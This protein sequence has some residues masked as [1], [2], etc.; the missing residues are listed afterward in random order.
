MVFNLIVLG[1]G[2]LIPLVV[3]MKSSE[4][5]TVRNC[6]YLCF[7]V[8]IYSCVYEVISCRAEGLTKYFSSF[9][10]GIDVFTIILYF[11]YFSY[12]IN[13]TGHAI[14]VLPAD[15]EH[16]SDGWFEREL[17]HELRYYSPAVHIVL[18]LTGF[19]K[20]MYYLRVSPKFG[21]FV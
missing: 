8:Q 1:F 11:V 10:N 9:W 3:Q 20:L 12:R 15:D 5:A 2:Y 17:E 14:P 18:I 19:T 21:E 4:P 16:K 13:H 6:N 7:V